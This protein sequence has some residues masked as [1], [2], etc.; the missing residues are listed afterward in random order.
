MSNESCF[1]ECEAMDYSDT[2]IHIIGSGSSGLDVGS[3]GF[4]GLGMGAGE[5]DDG[6][7]D[8]VDEDGAGGRGIPVGVGGGVGNVHILD[9]GGVD[10]IRAG[11]DGR[12]YGLVE[13]GNLGGGE[14]LVEQ[15]ELV[16]EAGEGVANPEVCK[17]A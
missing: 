6:R 13:G 5:G 10:C 4:P 16:Q 3:A 12:G 11:S 2:A 1:R 8:V 17:G 14:F 9:R 7:G 15:V